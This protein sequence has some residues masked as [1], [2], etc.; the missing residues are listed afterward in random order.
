MEIRLKYSN[1]D[2][3]EF[4]TLGHKDLTSVIDIFNGFPWQEET[5]KIKNIKEQISYPTLKLIKSNGEYAEINGFSNNDQIFYNV[6]IRYKKLIW[7]VVI[8]MK[9]DESKIIDLIKDFYHNPALVVLK[10]VKNGR[11][12]MNSGLMDFFIYN[13]RDKDILVEIEPNQKRY[14]AFTFKASRAFV[15]SLFSLIFLFMPLGFLILSNIQAWNFDFKGFLIFQLPML[16]FATPGLILT[17]NHVKSSKNLKLLFMKNNNEF[18]YIKD[19]KK[20]AFNKAD[21]KS[22]EKFITSANSKAPWS[23]FEYWKI[24]MKDGNVLNISDMIIGEMDFMKHFGLLI[25]DK[26]KK[27]K[28]LPLI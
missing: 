10:K 3:K 19:S 20:Q 22:L 15:K 6:K 2:S 25:L 7:R 23:M 27:K 8:G 11:F 4:K 13:S 12:T 16:L 28:F 9:L 1:Y 26:D 5:L 18:I 14:F 21:I 24:K 17:Y